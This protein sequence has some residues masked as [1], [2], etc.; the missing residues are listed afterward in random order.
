MKSHYRQ[1][2]NLLSR[3]Y[4]P[5]WQK[6]YYWEHFGM[7]ND[8]VYAKRTAIKINGTIKIFQKLIWTEENF[9]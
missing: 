8:E 2:E 1:R 3:F 7:M 4:S 6:E 5:Y 9:I